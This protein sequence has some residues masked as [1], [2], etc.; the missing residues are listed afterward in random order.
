MCS[1]VYG[2]MGSPIN[3]SNISRTGEHDS[4]KALALGYVACDVTVRRESVAYSAGGT[5]AN[6]AA[7]LSVLGWQVKLC[8]RIGVDIAGQ[9]VHD[10]LKQDGVD[11][12]ASYMDPQVFTPVVVVEADSQLPKYRFK[13]P[14]CGAPYAR[15]RPVRVFDSAI[16]DH[17]NV[18]FLD[19]TSVIGVEI[20]QKARA[21]GNLVIFEPNGLGHA[22]LFER[23][24]SISSV[25]KFSNERASGF[26]HL[27]DRG[28]TD[29]I[30]ICTLGENGFAVRNPLGEWHE[31]AAPKSHAVD[32]VG[33]GDIFTA[34]LLDVLMENRP[35]DALDKT[36]VVSAALQAQWFSIAH[37]RHK[38]A[39]GLTKG[40]DREEVLAEVD[41]VRTGKAKPAILDNSWDG[42]PLEGC[43]SWLCRSAD[44][45]SDATE[46]G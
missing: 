7:N 14:C 3:M 10:D 2:Y 17:T 5:S 40:R 28:P 26:R 24:V 29:Q 38:G 44:S 6:V 46:Q 16:L 32:T 41:A 42:A 21:M 23:L 43:G 18:V 34:A 19:R 13:C 4:K 39:R 36:E 22:G 9:L 12:S 27:L 11:L 30:Q 1:L 45:H 37:I 8:A 31:F 33:A 15:H 35:D 25:V 20:A